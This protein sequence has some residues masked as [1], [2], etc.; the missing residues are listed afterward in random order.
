MTSTE[1][2]TNIIKEDNIKLRNFLTVKETI[3]KPTS[4]W[5]R[6]VYRIHIQQGLTPRQKNND[7]TRKII[8]PTKIGTEVNTCFYTEDIKTDN[9]YMKVAYY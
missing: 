5:T 9:R 2:K 7:K 4:C 1:R 3:K 6:N 8:N